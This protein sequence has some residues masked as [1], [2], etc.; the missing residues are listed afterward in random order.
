[1]GSL[2][3]ELPAKVE[4]RE[5]HERYP[6]VLPAGRAEQA[7]SCLL[8]IS[9]RFARLVGSN[10]KWNGAGLQSLRHGTVCLMLCIGSRCLPQSRQPKGMSD[11]QLAWL[12][13]QVHLSTGA[14]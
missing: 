7:G 8:G 13:K 2:A 4:G 5:G 11:T 14:C 10:E 3:L 12:S 6:A 1:M 9:V